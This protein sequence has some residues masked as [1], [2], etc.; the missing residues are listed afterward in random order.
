MRNFLKCHCFILTRARFHPFLDTFCSWKPHNNKF[1]CVESRWFHLNSYFGRDHGCG[2]EKC[3][4]NDSACKRGN[5]KEGGFHSSENGEVKSFPEQGHFLLMAFL[6]L[7][8]S[9]LFKATDRAAVWFF[10]NVTKRHKTS[11]HWDSK[12]FDVLWNRVVYEGRSYYEMIQI[13]RKLIVLKFWDLHKCCHGVF[14]LSWISFARD[15]ML[16]F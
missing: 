1:I 12:M 5:R 15:T 9:L 7:P 8:G 16:I 14:D 2:V 6:N 4:C 13:E 3:C 11:Q 10:S